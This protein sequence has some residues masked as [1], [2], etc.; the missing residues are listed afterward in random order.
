[1]LEDVRYAVSWYGLSLDGGK[2]DSEVA[3]SIDTSGRC[4]LYLLGSSRREDSR[5]C[6]TYA[7]DLRKWDSRRLD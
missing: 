2:D 1:M 3:A 5:R 7:K 4:V 6:Q